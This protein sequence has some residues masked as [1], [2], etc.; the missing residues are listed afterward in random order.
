MLTSPPLNLN[1]MV[2][3]IRAY[4]WI[5]ENAKFVNLSK[6]NIKIEYTQD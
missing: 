3:G 2:S 5:N 6:A 1:F 4:N